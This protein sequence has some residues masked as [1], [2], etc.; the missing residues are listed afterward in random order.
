MWD[1]EKSSKTRQYVYIYMYIDKSTILL[2]KRVQNYVTFD[3][4]ETELIV[5]GVITTVSL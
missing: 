2:D 4:L 5:L 1:V 3:K